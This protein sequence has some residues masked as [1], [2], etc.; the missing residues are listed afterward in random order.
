MTRVRSLAAIVCLAVCMGA[1]TLNAQAWIGDYDDALTAI[2]RQDWNK[3]EQLLKAAIQRNPRQ[4]RRVFFRGTRFDVYIPE[5]YLAV[6]YANQ[7]RASEALDLFQKVER[8]GLVTAAT[9]EYSELRRLV[10]TS[11]D[12]V[13]KTRLAKA[14]GGRPAGPGAGA[15]TPPPGDGGAKAEDATA[16]AAR[17]EAERR[18]RF[19]SLLAQG[20]SELTNG[21]FDAARTHA[22]DAKALGVDDRRVAEFEKTIEIAVAEANTQAAVTKQDWPEAQRLTADLRK[23]DPR[24]AR[25]ASFDA[26][27]AKGLASAA[28]A[29]TRKALRAFFDGDYRTTIQLLE[30]AAADAQPSSRAL[31]YLAC[32]H[33]ALALLESPR[34]DER[35]QKGRQLYARARKG[36]ETFAVDRRFISPQVLRALEAPG[37]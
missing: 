8:D 29:V 9:P 33:A 14:D 20:A 21:R 36:T 7:Q 23:L 24:N 12:A 18:E 4:G 25:A 31:F 5:Y 34:G 15:V 35:L 28:T 16:V 22:A 1:V 2:K 30:P 13:E 10:A 37:R 6:V 11:R 32:S 3:A 27:I 17:R 19:A 26:A